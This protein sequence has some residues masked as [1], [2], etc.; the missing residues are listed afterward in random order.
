MFQDC[1]GVIRLNTKENR[2]LKQWFRDVEDYVED[3]NFVDDE[4][5]RKIIRY[6]LEWSG[7]RELWERFRFRVEDSFAELVILPALIDV[8]DNYSALSEFLDILIQTRKIYNQEQVSEE[9]ER[10]AKI[11]HILHKNM[12]QIAREFQ[13]E[14][15]Q[16]IG[17]LKKNDPKTQ[18]QIK[19][20]AQKKGRDGF[21]R[22]FYAVNQVEKD[23]NAVLI[24][25]VRDS[26]A[27]NQGAFDLRDKL[28]EVIS[29]A[30]ADDVAKTYDNV[31]R[32]ISQFSQE[33]EYLVKRVR[34]DDEKGTKELEHDERHVRL[35]YHTMRQAI[36]ARAEFFLQGKALAFEEALESLVKAQ[37]AR[38]KI[39]L[40]EGSVD[41]FIDFE[42]AVIS[43]LHKKL[44]QTLPTLPDK[45]FEISDD[46][47]QNR[48]KKTEVV[49]QKTEEVTRTKTEQETYTESYQSG[50]CFQSTKTRTK[51]RPITR[52]YKESVTRDITAD[53]EYVELFLPSPDLMA[54]QWLSGV[55]KGKE[56]LWDVL[57]NW[58]T[59]R[60]EYV[61]T[62]FEDSV[63]DITYLAERSLD[64]QLRIIEDNF[65]QEQ[66]FWHDFE[67]EKDYLT[68]ICQR[69]EKEFSES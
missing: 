48:S 63:N 28:R 30:L 23:L 20:N 27:Q 67:H 11:R 15:G 45:F 13:S 19:K 68:S 53:V 24:S 7:G 65:Q 62:L 64:K 47:K 17:G 59:K 38:L 33:S 5:M 16:L 60:L 40:S 8:F 44:A 52:K 46:I 3:N 41:S 50:S 12:N 36:S 51:T 29:P 69:L 31:S 61:K 1:A 35:L 21:A 34:A 32:R 57:L 37:V 6:S 2:E 39:C 54:K 18:I 10:L 14:V 49:G 4:T 42:K 55:D 66:E 58:I 26:F 22:I 43:D 56:S 9:R 25:P